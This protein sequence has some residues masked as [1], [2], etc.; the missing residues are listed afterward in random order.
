[1]SQTE[2]DAPRG[3]LALRIPA[4]PRDTNAAGDIFGGWIMGLMDMAAGATASEV[5]RGRVATVAVSNLEF[6]R[7]VKVGN[8]ISCFTEVAKIGR[9]SI[10]VDVD[11]WARR[12][13]D[14]RERVT[15][16]RFV[17]VAVDAEGR[18]RPV[19]QPTKD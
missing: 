1:M 4:V 16:A 15:K 2:P 19:P 9:T 3:E 7:P 13:A 14:L 17:M 12:H 8:L 11:V 18:P 10:T 5:A 6:L